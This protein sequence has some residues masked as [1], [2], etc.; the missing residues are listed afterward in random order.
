MAF[1]Q[2]YSVSGMLTEV[3]CLVLVFSRILV[4]SLT[5]VLS[6]IQQLVQVIALTTTIGMGVVVFLSKGLI[7]G[8][9][10]AIYTT[11]IRDAG[12]S[13]DVNLDNKK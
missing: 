3:Q 12:V 9:T 1:Q 2:V 4:G 11:M 13:T 10:K 7:G 6:I 5:S 8:I